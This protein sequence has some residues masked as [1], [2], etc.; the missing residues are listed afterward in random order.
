[1]TIP[2]RYEVAQLRR[3]AKR[4][5]LESIDQPFTQLVISHLRSER[6]RSSSPPTARGVRADPLAAKRHETWL[7][8]LFEDVDARVIAAHAQPGTTAARRRHEDARTS[9]G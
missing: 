7:V 2:D 6:S 1:M 5:D 9:T 4:S 8:D 3:F